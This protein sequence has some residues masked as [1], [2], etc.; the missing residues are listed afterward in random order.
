ML[1]CEPNASGVMTA[2]GAVPSAGQVVESAG[3]RVRDVLLLLARA[4]DCDADAANR[5]T[6]QTARNEIKMREGRRAY[7]VFPPYSRVINI[8]QY[9]KK[10]GAAGDSLL[11]ARG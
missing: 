2:G 11:D 3:I 8:S 1:R 7:I 10:Q 5:N 6:R 9:N 4:S